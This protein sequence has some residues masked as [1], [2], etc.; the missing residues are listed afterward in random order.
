MLSEN[1]PRALVEL[2]GLR[3][4]LSRLQERPVRLRGSRRK[5]PCNR[6]PHATTTPGPHLP[7][8]TPTLKHTTAEKKGE[9]EK[10]KRK[11]NRKQKQIRTASERATH[12]AQQAS[13]PD[14]TTAIPPPTTP[15]PRQAARLCAAQITEAASGRL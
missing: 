5:K 9:K 14:P 3:G 2:G 6:R 7:P 10:G 4:L 13:P 15:E 8:P 11:R 12:G 1:M